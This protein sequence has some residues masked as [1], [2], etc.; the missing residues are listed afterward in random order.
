MNSL[1][2]N[3]RQRHLLQLMKYWRLVFNDQF[4]IALFFMFGALAYTYAQ[5]LKTLTPGA[6]WI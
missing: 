3:R 1:F 6:W 5:W 2:K 4:T